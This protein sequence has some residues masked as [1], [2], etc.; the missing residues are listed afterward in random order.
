MHRT[1]K[2]AAWLIALTLCLIATACSTPAPQQTDDPPPT[3]APDSAPAPDNAPSSAP[4]SA[5]TSGPAAADTRAQQAT[6]RLQASEAG[7]L[8]LRSV[9][10]HGG[11]EAWFNGGALAFRYDYRPVK[12]EAKNSHQ[13]ID[14]LQARAYHNLTEP[15][16]GT[17]AWDGQQ[18]WSKFDD[19]Q[20]K[21]PA[22]FWALTPYY[23]VAM[24]FV[25]G[26]PGVNLTLIDDN[27][28][29]VG[30]PPSDV[31]RVTFNPGTG[32][33]PDDYYIVYLAKD[34]GRMLALRYV[35]SWKPFVQP[36]NI[37]HTPEKLLVYEDHT[38]VGPLTMAQKHTTYMM[39]DGK[40]GDLVTNTAV[41]ELTYKAPFDASRLTAPQG[42][43]FDRTLE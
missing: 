24:P 41:S 7:K 4:S 1:R 12:G 8:A 16:T 36:Q 21:F 15:V 2:H 31:L 26:D 30:L 9:N 22:R 11:F 18:A 25:L 19:P 29:D 33:A 20:A 34:D 3:K 39:K 23:F 13:T 10:K 43:V 5:P 37:A 27:P 28:A 32:D 35:V 17:I 6:A 38:Q 40:R 42:A 14:L